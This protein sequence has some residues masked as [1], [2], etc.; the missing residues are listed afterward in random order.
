MEVLNAQKLDQQD[1]LRTVSSGAEAD[2]EE[3]EEAPNE[4]DIVPTD[5]GKKFGEIKVTELKK[6]MMF[7]EDHPEVVSERNQD[8]LMIFAF[9]AQ[10]EGK[11]SLAKQYV[12]Q[13]LLL[14]YAKQVG[15]GG[16][17]T[18]FM[19][20][21]LIP[22]LSD[23]RIADPKHKAHAVFYEDV[24]NTHTRIR[25]R[26][27]EILS[28]KG[29][30]DAAGGVEQIQLQAVDP[31][32]AIHINVPPPNSDDPAI[33]QARKIFE[34]F[35]PGLQRALER[36]ALEDIN[37]VLGKMAVDEAEEIVELLGQGGMLSI[38]PTIID[39]TKGETI[40]ERLAPHGQ[41]NLEEVREEELD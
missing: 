23:F 38:E 14:Q 13:A 40:P 30:G 33:Q 39:T 25:T 24:N 16:I 21:N 11:E 32:T 17:K 4:D 2:S 22:T 26:T 18:F 41:P 15:R 8:G 36:G 28:A 20:Y 27:K 19:G 5:V 35:P 6:S 3:S 1:S 29:I 31:N 9:N 7:I 34:A 10:M 37:V 12:H